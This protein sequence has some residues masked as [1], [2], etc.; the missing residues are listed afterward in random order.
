MWTHSC[1]SSTSLNPTLVGLLC[2]PT[3]S[4]NVMSCLARMALSTLLCSWDCSWLAT[5]IHLP[6]YLLF[7]LVC[8]ARLVFLP[9]NFRN[10]DLIEKRLYNIPKSP[11][12]LRLLLGWCH[13]LSIDVCFRCFLR[14]LVHVVGPP[15][16]PLPFQTSTALACGPSSPVPFCPHT[17]IGRGYGCHRLGKYGAGRFGGGL[18]GYHFPPCD[19]VR[20][21][22]PSLLPS[23]D[24][25][26][27]WEATT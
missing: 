5:I 27:V 12:L 6:T 10:G 19:C 14:A 11:W 7:W 17:A 22:F 13:H 20:V 23:M 3:C 24:N 8:V 21:R 4:P 16:L 2:P 18:Y 15:S 26:C 9:L 25:V 1:A